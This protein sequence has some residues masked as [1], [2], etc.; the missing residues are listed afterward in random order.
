[1]PEGDRLDI[2]AV[3]RPSGANRCNV[4]AEAIPVYVINLNR[5]PDRRAAIGQH[6]EA[7][8]IDWQRVEAVDGTAVDAGILD[9][10]CARTGPN[11]P[12]GNPTRACTASHLRAWEEFLQGTAGFALVLEDNVRLASDAAACLCSDAWIPESVDL[13]KLEKFNP[14]RSSRL[15]LG[16]KIAAVP[17]EGGQ[18]ET[19]ELREM[20]SRHTG[21]GAYIISRRAAKMALKHRG[22]ID[23]PIDHFLFNE[24]VSPLLRDL[25]PFIVRPSMAWQRRE[26]HGS[27]I[28]V[29]AGADQLPFLSRK[30]RSLRRAWFEVKLF[31]KQMIW[32]LTGRAAIVELR[33]PLDTR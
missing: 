30:L 21:A 6:L 13:I 15:L 3:D 16:R 23:V 4:N 24:T 17:G 27:D 18:G 22:G 2:M 7:L 9:E 29:S 1:M 31:P 5:R 19:R 26:D 25:R 12:M 20:F 11:G 10:V 8:G 32:L 33:G 14:A 28:P